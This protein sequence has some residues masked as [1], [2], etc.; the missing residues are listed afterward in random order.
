MKKQAITIALCVKDGA[1]VL[2]ESLPALAASLARQACPVVIVN[3]LSTDHTLGLLEEWK[4]RHPN[5][6][7]EILTCLKAGISNARNMAWRAVK[8][9]W[10]AFIDADCIAS[11][12]WTLRAHDLLKLPIGMDPFVVGIGGRN[13]VPL[14][15]GVFYHAL[16]ALLNSFVGGHNSILNRTFSGNP[17]VDHVPTL[18]VLY[19]VSALEKV[20]GFDP[21]ISRVGEDLD[22]SARLRQVGYQLVADSKWTVT[23]LLRPDLSSWLKNMYLYGQGRIDH[24]QRHRET[25]ALKFMIPSFAAIGYIVSILATP[26]YGMEPLLAV[27][28]AHF[29]VVSIDL[30]R[31]ARSNPDTTF[32]G[33]FLALFVV[34][35]TH[36]SYG[37]GSLNQIT[38]RLKV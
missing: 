2:P 6:E 27:L 32:I 15:R 33:R 38:K 37:L 19:R 3:H 9:E 4:R 22:L 17:T 5:L 1:S 21:T 23:H 20:N 34:V 12:D 25:F 30:A 13:L 28:G 16:S 31:T 10:V 14:H 18:N 7:I 26:L 36:L 8:S 29:A 11:P 24:I 35:F